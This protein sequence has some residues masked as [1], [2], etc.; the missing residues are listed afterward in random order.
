MR[1]VLAGIDGSA[2]SVTAATWAAAEAALRSAPLWLVTVEDS[3]TSHDW[4]VV[5]GVVERCRREH[6]G[7]DVTGVVIPGFAAD[8]LV[9]QSA[10]AQLLVVG[11]RGR[12]AFGEALLGSVSRAAVER[13]SC[14]VVVVPRRRTGS[15]LGP[16]VFGVA[17]PAYRSDAVPFAFAEAAIRRTS[18]LGVHVWQPIVGRHTRSETSGPLLSTVDHA[19]SAVAA[20][21][22]CWAARYPEVQLGI[23]VRCGNPAEELS[24]ASASAQLLVLGHRSTVLGFGSVAHGA[25]H[26]ADCPVAVVAETHHGEDA[27]FYSGR[28]D[29]GERDAEPTP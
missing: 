27:A 1:R 20:Y 11:S 14:P 2:E 25:L 18:L 7:I 17:D 9:R 5:R 6:R 13:A 23:E 19:R 21:L 28:G 26:R 4:A 22:T 16:V 15:A 24:R 29:A 12:G 8:A 3:I 10:D